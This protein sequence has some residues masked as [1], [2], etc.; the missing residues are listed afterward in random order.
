M[1]LRWRDVRKRGM[2]LVCVCAISAPRNASEQANKFGIGS[3]DP[4]VLASL[5]VPVFIFRLL[6]GVA[7]FNRPSNHHPDSA[8]LWP[9]IIIINRS[10]SVLVVDTTMWS[11]IIFA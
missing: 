2:G 3:L 6:V 9:I 1:L 11:L 10:S 5:H 8:S 7:A 4:C